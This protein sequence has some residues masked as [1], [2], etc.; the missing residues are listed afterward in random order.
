MVAALSVD[1]FDVCGVA[2]RAHVY[3]RPPGDLGKAGAGAYLEIGGV[4]VLGSCIIHMASD[5]FV[6]VSSWSWVL[7]RLAGTLSR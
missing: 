5:F 1:V 7:S 6:F 3:C 2:G 4:F